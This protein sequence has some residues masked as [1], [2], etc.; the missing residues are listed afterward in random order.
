MEIKPTLKNPMGKSIIQQASSSAKFSS[1]FSSL[2][3][4][5]DAVKFGY[6]PQTPW[7]KAE[8]VSDHPAADGFVS[9]SKRKDDKKDLPVKG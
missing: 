8:V 7:E 2:T 6:Q 3:P 4:K 5:K 1:L 9:R